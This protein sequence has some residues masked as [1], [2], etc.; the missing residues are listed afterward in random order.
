MSS[1]EVAAVDPELSGQFLQARGPF[2]V[3]LGVRCAGWLCVGAAAMPPVTVGLALALASVLVSDLLPLFHRGQ[4]LLDLEQVAQFAHRDGC[5]VA[6]EPGEA[7]LE[8]QPDLLGCAQP[9]EIDILGFVQ[10]RHFG[11]GRVAVQDA[12][13]ATLV[14]GIAEHQGGNLTQRDTLGGQPFDLG[15]LRCCRFRVGGHA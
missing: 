4:G 3:C 6:E 14:T 2:G 1:G 10:C 11:G 9:A 13:N 8:E 15:P 7:A 12:L 5:L